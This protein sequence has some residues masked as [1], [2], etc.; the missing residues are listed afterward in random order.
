M[1][2]TV[3]VRQ[4]IEDGARLLRK[5]DERGIPVSAAAWFDDPDQS[6]WKLVVVTSVAS[7]PGPLEAYMQIQF[8]MNGLDLN[9]SLDDITVM[10]PYSRKFEAF[11][12]TM[13]GAAKG[14]L[15]HPTNSSEGVAFDD[16]Y[17]YR[18]QAK[19]TGLPID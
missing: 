17:V 14:A 4:M 3:L 16:A 8:A 7:N 18:W 5:L 12:R 10:S 9:I 11:R 6:A 1:Y 19:Y 2:K 13:E 15:L